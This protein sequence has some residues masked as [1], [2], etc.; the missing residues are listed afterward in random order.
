MGQSLSH[1]GVKGMHWGV[2]R[3][4]TT[5]VG[6]NTVTTRNGKI[7]GVELAKKTQNTN[8]ASKDAAVTA[9]LK[10]KAKAKSVDSLSN[11]ELKKLVARMN[12]EQQYNNLKKNDMT[13]AQKF[14]NELF[15]R[16]GK[17]HINKLVQDNLGKAVG[18]ALKNGVKH[19]SGGSPLAIGS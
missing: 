16:E 18:G 9:V 1:Y 5:A 7:K 4:E 14:V 2:T 3:A 19:K 13:P 15:E 17:K 12:L 11:D 6:R 8:T 10:S